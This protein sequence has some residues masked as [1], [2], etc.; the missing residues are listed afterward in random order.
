VSGLDAV[1]VLLALPTPTLGAS[2]ALHFLHRAAAAARKLLVAGAFLPAVLMAEHSPE[3]IG[4]ASGQA[5]ERTRRDQTTWRVCYRPLSTDE[6][7]ARVLRHVAA[8][9]PLASPVVGL[10]SLTQVAATTSAPASASASAATKAATNAAANAKAAAAAK[11]QFL[12]G[13]LAPEAA[14]M[15]AVSAFLT[16]LL[17]GPMA[18]KHRKGWGEHPPKE[19]LAFFTSTPFVPVSAT[20]A[21]VASSV[22]IDYFVSRLS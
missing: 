9:H 20:E 2:A 7:V 19:S 16:I 3:G 15:H 13:A 14:A 11:Q 12:L 17:Q 10:G 21:T 22:R 18:F 4:Q 6:A 8:A 1:R 5:S